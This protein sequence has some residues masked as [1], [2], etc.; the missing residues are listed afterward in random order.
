MDNKFDENEIEKI[1]E[2]NEGSKDNASAYNGGGENAENFENLSCEEKTSALVEEEAF[3]SE[4]GDASVEGQSDSI[5]AKPCEEEIHRGDEVKSAEYVWT[6]DGA[7][8]F[9]P[10]NMKEYVGAGYNAEETLPK[11]EKKK[12]RKNSLLWLIPVAAVLSLLVGIVGGVIV[13][14]LIVDV[15][16]DFY[17]TTVKV[18]MD[19]N[20]APVDVET[21][22]S[23][24]GKTMLSRIQVV[25]MVADAVVEVSTSNIVTNSLFGNYIISGGGS[26]VVIAQ[27]EKYAYIVTNQHV[28]EGASSIT[29][30]TTDGE[31][32]EVE[33]LDGD[34]NMDIAMLRIETTKQFPKIVCGSSSNIRVGEDVIAI[35][36]ALG[37]LGGTVTD[38]IVSALDRRITIEGTTMVLMQTNAAVNPGN[39]GGG[40]FNMAGELVGIVN[41]KESATGVEGLG[42]AIPID[43]IYDSL[44]EIIESNY[45]HGRPTLKFETEYVSDLWEA[46]VKYRVNT[47]GVFVTSSENENIKV[48][49]LI[50]AVNGQLIT[51]D[52][53]YV[54]AISSLEVGQTITIDFYRAGDDGYWHEQTVDVVVEEYVPVGIFG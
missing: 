24:A 28:V 50:K 22:T 48:G 5:E 7:Y 15:D 47:T 14:R 23:D 44:I 35:G 2:I 39:S 25:N 46:R 42:F 41:A 11:K 43:R 10:E 34:S 54:A 3:G 45:I 9:K 33:Y 37:E 40:L 13:S 12:K 18:Q 29:V 20:E 49:D 8:H 31:E 27:N 19:K 52:T 17:D 4:E 53:S 51:D 32:F 26:G 6:S 1:N 30:R 36:N 16:Y 38:G 21:I